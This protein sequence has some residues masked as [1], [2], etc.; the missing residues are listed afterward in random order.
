V[1]SM[2]GQLRQGIGLTLLPEGLLALC[3]LHLPNRKGGGG[4]GG[5]VCGRWRGWKGAIDLAF[6]VA[7][8][9]KKKKKKNGGEIKRERWRPWYWSL[10]SQGTMFMGGNNF[11]RPYFFFMK[12]QQFNLLRPYIFMKSQ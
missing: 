11:L 1:S 5:E 10:L 6:K 9:K 12:S 8:K 2:Q 3:Y 7:D 4:G